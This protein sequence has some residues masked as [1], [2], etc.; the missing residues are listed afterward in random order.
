MLDFVHPM[1]TRPVRWA[2]LV[3]AAFA[4]SLRAGAAA[5]RDWPQFR[6]PGGLG[7]A[8]EA[9]LPVRWSATENVAW[10]T[11]I[12]GRGWSSPIVWRGRVYVTSAVSS[13]SFEQPST[14]IYGNDYAAELTKQGLPPDEVYLR[15]ATK[16]YRILSRNE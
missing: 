4:A 10:T 2:G 6:G 16:L 13:G 7:V 8:D 9:K 1:R 12:P 3:L 14:G 5:P 15:T 11:E